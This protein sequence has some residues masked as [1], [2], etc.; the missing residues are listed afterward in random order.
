[1]TLEHQAR[2]GQYLKQ[3]ALTGNW[4]ILSIRPKPSL[5]RRFRTSFLFTNAYWGAG[6]ACA[7]GVLFAMAF[8]HIDFPTSPVSLPIAVMTSEPTPPQSISIATS[9]YALELTDLGSLPPPIAVG[10][11]TEGSTGPIPVDAG[12]VQAE[13][14]KP[15]VAA[16]LD[17][18]AAELKPTAGSLP[19]PPIKAE[20][21]P[22]AT[23]SRLPVSAA[24]VKPAEK[25]PLPP[26]IHLPKA[27]VK[28]A[29]QTGPKAATQPEG[30]NE[31]K[32]AV[33]NEP[34]QL[35]KPSAGAV[36]PP[37]IASAPQTPASPR[38]PASSPSGKNGVRMLA[39][40]G[41]TSI[42][43]TNPSNRLPMVVK[44]GEALP[45]GSVLKSIDK[46]A[47][48]AVN[49]RGEVLVLQ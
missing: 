16:P 45:D 41:P 19:P 42:V 26:S 35:A 2:E 30:Q 22:V 23:P 8:N 21:A 15:G 31:G 39:V 17:K 29:V 47:S 40:Q 24:A 7:A 4:Q 18:K 27:A 43:V 38:S 44:V 3:D 48:T 5:W 20:V 1:M 28:Q 13:T 36:L 10:S 33:F 12:S 9:T 14:T 11:N 25:L 46:T 32:I 49:S 37:P 6:L 34:L